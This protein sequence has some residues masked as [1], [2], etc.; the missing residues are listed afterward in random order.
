[1]NTTNFN[2]DIPVTGLDGKQLT[3]ETGGMTLG[4]VLAPVIAGQSK[5]DALK[6]FGWALA[7]YKGETLTLDQ[8]DQNTLKD[9]IR[10]SENLT[11]LAKAQLLNILK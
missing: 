11:V 1:M 6:L 8:S 2:F 9:F 7:M 5:G 4:G 10:E 3:N